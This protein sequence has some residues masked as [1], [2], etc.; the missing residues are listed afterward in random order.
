MKEQGNR[1]RNSLIFQLALCLLALPG[2]AHASVSPSSVALKV[3]EVISDADLP[4][5][6]PYDGKCDT[7]RVLHGQ[8]ECTLR[9]AIEE[10]AFIN[11]SD[12]DKEMANYL[13]L[14]ENKEYQL[15]APA[16]EGGLT[17][18]VTGSLKI[19][20]NRPQLNMRIQ[21]VTGI[22]GTTIMGPKG[23]I[24]EK[25]DRVLLIMGNKDHK[26]N[27][28]LAGL[29]IIK[30]KATLANDSYGN[31]G[32]G[33]LVINYD[34]APQNAS[35]VNLS[36]LDSSVLSN[37]A[38]SGGG[39]ASWFAN[40][41]IRRSAIYRNEANS[42]LISS[43]GGCNL[44]KFNAAGQGGGM[45]MA[46]GAAN[47][48]N[49]TIGENQAEIGGGIA[50]N[51]TLNILNSTI[52]KNS[53]SDR[54]GGLFIPPHPNQAPATLFNTILAN[55]SAWS[56]P[57]CG[58]GPINGGFNLIGNKKGCNYF[59][60]DPTASGDLVGHENNPLDPGL[61]DLN[62][63]GGPTPTYPPSLESPALDH[64]NSNYCNQFYN[65]DHDQRGA[66]RPVGAGC[67]MGAHEHG[68]CG[69]GFRDPPEDCDGGSQCGSNCKF[70]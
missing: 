52:Y 18:L 53:A 60:S 70:L 41:D 7:G 30:G 16:I 3:I 45:G 36:L 17:G 65:N 9:A 10:A 58:G 29:N 14:L 35:D 12:P 50:S 4:D 49:S 39:I 26:M 32:G 20:S 54:G 61:S 28:T 21:G 37:R 51:A 46:G 59:K 44:K 55:N 40:L 11:D 64:G 6:N 48:A 1:L 43:V 5:V 42:S 68:T 8:P 22:Q 47:I 27:I 25:N 2:F 31:A 24:D 69:D 67:D 33:I 66:M 56:S 62:I 15:S 19:F 34:S 63:T 38:I 23:D 57:D 13:I